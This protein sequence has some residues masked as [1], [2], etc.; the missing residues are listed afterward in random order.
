M[1]EAG[2]RLE[3]TL[4]VLGE[5]ARTAGLPAPEIDRTIRSAYRHAAARA[6]PAA[7]R[8]AS[9]DRLGL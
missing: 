3:A 8:T 1:V 2:H 7:P 5:A 9:A 4:S 6:G